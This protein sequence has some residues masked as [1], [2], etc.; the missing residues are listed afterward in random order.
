[1]SRNIRSFIT[2]YI[3]SCHVIPGW[4]GIFTK[5]QK[6]S[7]SSKSL[8]QLML[9]AKQLY[10]LRTE[11]NITAGQHHNISNTD[12]NRWGKIYQPLHFHLI[13]C[14]TSLTD[15]VCC[16]ISSLAPKAF[17]TTIPLVQRLPKFNMKKTQFIYKDYFAEFSMVRHVI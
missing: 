9:T 13:S 6:D 16:G 17:P 1:M 8:Q 12:Q 7:P 4:Q 5:L 11:E 2:Q 14:S 3:G 15:A 10:F